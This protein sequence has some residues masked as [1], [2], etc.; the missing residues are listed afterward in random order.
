MET[1]AEPLVPEALPPSSQSQ[2]QGKAGEIPWLP[3]AAASGACAAFNGVFAKLYA[4]L[5]E[6]IMYKLIDA[7]Q[8]PSSPHPGPPQ[9]LHFSISLQQTSSLNS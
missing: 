4:P 7:A 2:P 3:L 6:C 8:P 1:E 9:S 5:Y